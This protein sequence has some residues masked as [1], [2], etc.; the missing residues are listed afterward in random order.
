MAVFGL[1]LGIVDFGYYL[2]FH[3]ISLD[4]SKVDAAYENLQ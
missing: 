1:G 3:Y 2:N 4:S